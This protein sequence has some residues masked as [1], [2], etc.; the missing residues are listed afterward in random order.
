MRPATSVCQARDGPV[1]SHA[2]TGSTSAP[3]S[4]HDVENLPLAD[5]GLPFMAESLVTTEENIQTRRDA[6][7]GFLVTMIKCWTDAVADPE[8]SARLAVEEYGADLGLQ[9]DK[10]IRQAQEQNKLVSTAEPGPTA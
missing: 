1:R 4:A 9:M 6:L 3:A 7:K 2:S 5:N 8:E 10:E